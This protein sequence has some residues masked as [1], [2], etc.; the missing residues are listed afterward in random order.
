MRLEQNKLKVIYVI[1]HWM[2]G[3]NSKKSKEQ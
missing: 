2:E 3:V 1:I